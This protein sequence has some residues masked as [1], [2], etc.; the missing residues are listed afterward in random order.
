[1]L[2][3]VVAGHAGPLAE[4]PVVTVAMQAMRLRNLSDWAGNPFSVVLAVTH[5]SRSATSEP[6]TEY[7]ASTPGNPPGPRRFRVDQSGA[8]DWLTFVEPSERQHADAKLYRIPPDLAVS[9]AHFPDADWKTPLQLTILV[10][11]AH[12]GEQLALRGPMAVVSAAIMAG[13][14]PRP[15]RLGLVQTLN[16]FE[17]GGIFQSVRRAAEYRSCIDERRAA[18]RAF[19]ES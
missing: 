14:A 18:K 15:R 8:Y 5:G 4:N 7:L 11:D 12:N 10:R 2:G 16:P 6:A 17:E 9:H 3:L 1:M 19:A 13:T